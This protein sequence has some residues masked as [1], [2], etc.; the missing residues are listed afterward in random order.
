MPEIDPAVYDR[1]LAVPDVDGGGV[2]LLEVGRV[3]PGL[4]GGGGEALAVAK[5]G[6]QETLGKHNFRFFRT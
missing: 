3:H 5:G 1:V 4:G 2:G 6:D